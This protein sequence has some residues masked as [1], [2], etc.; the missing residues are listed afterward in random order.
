MNHTVLILLLIVCLPSLAQ[1][2][3]ELNKQ[4]TSYEN[5]TIHTTSPATNDSQSNVLHKTGTYNYT[6]INDSNDNSAEFY[7]AIDSPNSYIAEETYIQTPYGNENF[8]INRHSITWQGQLQQPKLNFSPFSNDYFGYIPLEDTFGIKQQAC[9]VNCKNDVW[10]WSFEF[11]FQGRTVDRFYIDRQGE[12]FFDEERSNQSPYAFIRPLYDDGTSDNIEVRFAEIYNPDTSDVFLVIEWSHFENNELAN[13][14]QFIIQ[15]FTNKIWF[16]YLDTKGV[17]EH[18]V[19]SVYNANH[20]HGFNILDTTADYMITELLE[21][22]NQTFLIINEGGEA[23]E[24]ST[25]IVVREVNNIFSDMMFETPKNT[26][27]TIEL[28]ELELIGN[29]DITITG[30]NS[31]VQKDT[32]HIPLISK[33][34]ELGNI[35]QGSSGSVSIVGNVITYTPNSDFIGEDSFKL[36]IKEG[37]KTSKR[38]TIKVTI[39]P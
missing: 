30:S 17:N 22:N 15:E 1:Q 16:N 21:G 6:F 35:V 18:S 23:A 24:L 31:I 34:V 14:Y 25:F 39:T 19:A 33:Y 4:F 13:R 3:I 10:W 38:E 27:L 9:R 11:E 36:D 5:K 28:D 20:Q 2:K 7:M 8:L 26:P 29:V 32:L 12:V 37:Y